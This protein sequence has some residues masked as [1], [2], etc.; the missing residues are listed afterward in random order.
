MFS[1]YFYFSFC[2][3]FHISYLYR[4]MVRQPPDLPDLLLQQPC[5]S[6]VAPINEVEISTAT[7]ST[8]LS[9]RARHNVQLSCRK[10]GS[11]M[12]VQSK[13][14]PPHFPP[15]T[16]PVA[17]ISRRGVT[18]MLKVYVCTHNVRLGEGLGPCSHRKLLEIGCSEIPFWDR[19]RDVV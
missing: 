15:K 16:R 9:K 10:F 4:I 7:F 19:T 3:L 11:R 1:I 14:S 5:I 8:I 13:F 12:R 18:W 17:M 6:G 2:S